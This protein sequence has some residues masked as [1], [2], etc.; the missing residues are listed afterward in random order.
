MAVNGLVR[1]MELLHA[2]GVAE[3]LGIPV[4]TLANWRASGKGRTYAS[5]RTS[6]TALSMSKPGSPVVCVIREPSYLAGSLIGAE[7][8]WPAHAGYDHPFVS[9]LERSA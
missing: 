3:L 6:G 7:P 2:A 8:R 5:A 9:R 1:V 4:A